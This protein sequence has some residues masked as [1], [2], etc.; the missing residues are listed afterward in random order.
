VRRLY[1]LL[2]YLALPFVLLAGLRRARRE[3]AAGIAVGPEGARSLWRERLALD[4]ADEVGDG[5]GGLLW[6]HAASVGEVQLAAELI[7]ALRARA[8]QQ[9]I[10]L[11]CNTATGRA[12]AQA[13]LPQVRV[14]YAPYD[15]PAALARRL[16]ALQ[17]RALVLMETEL[18][19]NLLHAATRAGIPTLIA[20][21]RLSERSLRGYRRL[22]SLFKPALR[23]RLWVGAQT[24]ADAARFV[25]L[26][27]P[28]ERVTVAGNLKFDRTIPA[29][30]RARGR[31]L[32]ALLGAA[33]PVWV[34]GS[35]HPVEQPVLLEAHRQLLARQPQALL[36]LAPRHPPRFEEAASQLAKQGWRFHRRSSQ[37][38]G[39]ALAADCQV[40]LLDTLGELLDFYAAGDVAF[41]GG[42]LAPLGGHNL[43]EPAA[44]GLPVLAGA[45]QSNSPEVARAL[46]E[47]GA[48][49]IVA[50]AGQLATR[51][52]GLL[53]SEALRRTQAE[54]ASAA[55]ESHRGALGR[56]LTLIDALPPLGRLSSSAALPPL[57]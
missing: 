32:R 37:T 5:G 22:E 14:R 16:S 34:A 41:V 44:L 49:G 39:D 6:V 23:Q 47:A 19:P 24:A 8:P 9:P 56:L 26:G 1:T 7:G 51:L 52:Q 35:T 18:W 27:V 13:L 3:Q 53:A 50:D 55:L 17:P 4:E 28:V 38:H 43:L 46:G 15:L 25:A 36:V 48:L 11:S 54:R 31:Q 2:W 20:S 33:R 42:S 10:E 21:A 40:L 45:H 29:E 57:Q 30:T 12:R